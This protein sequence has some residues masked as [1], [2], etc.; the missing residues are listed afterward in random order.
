[1]LLG[2]PVSADWVDK[3]AAPGERAAREA[4]FDAAMLAALADEDVLAADETPVN[5]L[6]WMP[7]PGC[8]DEERDSSTAA[9]FSTGPENTELM[10]ARRRLRERDRPAA[11]AQQARQQALSRLPDDLRVDDLRPPRARSLR[12]G[13]GRP[14]GPHSAGRSTVLASSG[15]GSRLEPF[16]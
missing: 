12:P 5:L 2:I 15:C 8:R 11:R 6:D 14:A 3:A 9:A 4:G 10:R 13:Q 7:R 1:M 16:P